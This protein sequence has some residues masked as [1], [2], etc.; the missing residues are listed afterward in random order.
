MY[1]QTFY[2]VMNVEMPE[3]QALVHANDGEV[4]ESDMNSSLGRFF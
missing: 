2:Q 3:V 4:T 1:R